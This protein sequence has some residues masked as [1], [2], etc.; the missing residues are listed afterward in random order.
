MCASFYRRNRFKI[1]ETS[2]SEEEW[3]TT[4]VLKISDLR[5]SD[6]GEYLCQAVSSMGMA[7]ATLRLHGECLEYFPPSPLPLKRYKH[8]SK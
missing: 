4:T 2:N 6:L 8:N 1:E 5:K 3:K 7:N